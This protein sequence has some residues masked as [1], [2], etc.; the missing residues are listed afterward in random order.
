MAFGEE[1]VAVGGAWEMEDGFLD[2]GGEVEKVH[3][4]RDA[5]AGY[6]AEFGEFRLVADGTRAEK[7]VELYR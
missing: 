7:V 3:Y 5:G 6:V 2:V 4:L 1:V